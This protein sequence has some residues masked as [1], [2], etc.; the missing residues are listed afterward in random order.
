MQQPGGGILGNILGNVMGGM[1]QGGATPQ[2]TQAAPVQQ[3]GVAPG[4]MPGMS[5]TMQAGLDVL[6]GMFQAGAQAQQ[7]H[8]SV[9]QEIISAAMRGMPR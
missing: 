7:A 3:P 4:A 6:T 5:P 8:A 2:P 9:L 1:V